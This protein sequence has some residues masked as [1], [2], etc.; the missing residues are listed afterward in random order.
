MII[1]IHVD[2]CKF[3]GS[4][5]STT[6]AA[7][8]T[9]TH[10]TNISRILNDQ[11][12]TGGKRLNYLNNLYFIKLELPYFSANDIPDEIKERI[13]MI[14]RNAQADLRKTFNDWFNLHLNENNH[15][16]LSTK[17]NLILT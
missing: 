4:Y 11:G 5:S 3:A 8:A 9:G 13:E 12:N 1:A 7:R 16:E 14:A 6:E 17:Q 15:K 10:R 2:T